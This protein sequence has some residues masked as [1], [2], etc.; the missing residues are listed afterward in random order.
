MKRRLT[1]RPIFSVVA[2]CL[3]VVVLAVSF[4]QVLG[5]FYL[6]NIVTGDDAE[7]GPAYTSPRETNGKKKVLRLNKF[8]YYTIEAANRQDGESAQQIAKI[9]AQKGFA[10]VVTGQP[11]F[12]I[13]LDL[14]NNSEVLR[15]KGE[16]ISID[17]QKAIVVK[18]TV[19]EYSFKFSAEDSFAA[20][21]IAPFLGAV[22]LCLE[23]A[24]PLFTDTFGVQ[25]EKK[26]EMSARVQ[27]LSALLEKT[28][29]QGTG[30]IQSNPDENLATELTPLVS[31]LKDWSSNAV[32]PQF[33]LALLEVFNQ[34]LYKHAG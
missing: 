33:A 31:A 4:G 1:P 8:D 22:S 23:K 19:N 2:A 32:N 5:R 30:I 24:L 16:T 10:P 26:S 20:E 17:G 34:F 21:K 11:P 3:L 6:K 9:L 27:E 29:L 15:T 12:R 28:V 14:A 7:R 13:L 18:G 25:A